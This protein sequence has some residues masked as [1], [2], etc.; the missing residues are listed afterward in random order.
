MR[1]LI[2]AAL[3]TVILVFSACQQG[4]GSEQSS[5]QQDSNI[6]RTYTIRSSQ[7]RITDIGSLGYAEAQYDF[8]ELSSEVVSR[9]LVHA[10][11]QTNEP[12][13]EAWLPLPFSGTVGV[14]PTT[15]TIDLT[16]AYVQGKIALAVYS[17]VP[18]RLLRTG[19]STLNGWK[20]RVVIDP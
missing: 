9:G 2:V 12:S 7:L 20:M 18:A 11:I 4:P 19:L 14:S 15:V 8:P 13:D 1:A 6:T 17:N 10:Y 3:S 5:R 16:Y